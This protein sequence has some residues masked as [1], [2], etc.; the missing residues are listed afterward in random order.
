MCEMKG[1]AEAVTSTCADMTVVQTLVSTS[2]DRN[3]TFGKMNRVGGS[4]LDIIVSVEGKIL[5]RGEE[6]VRLPVAHL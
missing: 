2:I 5:G 4:L 3:R 1:R 6:L